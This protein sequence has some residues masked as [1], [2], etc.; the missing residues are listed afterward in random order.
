MEIKR[1]LNT[2]YVKLDKEKCILTIAGRSYP[3]SPSLFYN[4]FF[5]IKYV[6]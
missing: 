4:Y 3:E 6:F 5:T 1:K 2:P